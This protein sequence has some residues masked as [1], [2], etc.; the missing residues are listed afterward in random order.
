MKM[1]NKVRYLLS[2]FFLWRISLFAVAWFSVFI[3]PK[4]INYETSWL[5]DLSQY[6]FINIWLRWDAAYYNAIAINGYEWIF[7]TVFFPLYPFLMKII[8]HLIPFDYPTVFAGLLISNLSLIV[9]LFYLYELVKIDYEEKI[10]KRTVFYLLI[11]PMSIFL[12]SIYSES[13]FLMFAV[14]SFYYARKQKWISVSLLVFLS[15]LTRFAG[16][17]LF[18]GILFEYFQQKK[19]NIKSIKKSEIIPLILAPM[20]LLVYMAFLYINFGDPLLF[21][22]EQINWGRSFKPLWETIFFNFEYLTANTEDFF[23]IKYIRAIIAPVYFSFFI[24]LSI[25]VWKKIRKSYAVY[26]II[27]VIVPV[28]SGTFSSINRYYLVL[29]PAFICF[30]LWGNRKIVNI[31]ISVVFLSFLVYF[32]V[33]F[34][35][36][37]WVG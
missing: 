23:T 20:G 26:M 5:F 7:H 27:S 18:L 11:F 14:S 29:F 4:N 22:K 2:L 37:Y 36:L 17:F 3:V 1:N 19:T 25:Y 13:L 16:L 21:I 34:V 30:A 10:S 28:L 6:N 8:S 35:N 24:F 12:A 15:C 32:T 33:M 31:I 9:A